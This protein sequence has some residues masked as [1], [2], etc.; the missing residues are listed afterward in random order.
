MSGSIYV[1]QESGELIA[2]HETTYD[3]E[4]LL[5]GL[6]AKHPD[7]LA[8][9]QM[10]ADTP[11]RWLL[12]SREM[13]VPGSDDST[14]RW[15]LDHLFLDQDAVPTLVEVKRSCDTRIRREVVGQLLDYAANG[16][17]YWPVETVQARFEASCAADGRDPAVELSTLIG[18]DGDPSAFW[19]QVKTNLQAGRIRLVF[20]ADVIP[21]EL[22]RVIEFLNRQ[23]DPAEVLGVEVK[24][25][26]GPGVTTLVPRV[27]GILDRRKPAMVSSERQPISEHEFWRV[28]DEAR[29][30]PERAA[31]RAI[32]EWSRAKGLS[33]DFKTG[34]KGPVFVATVDDI[35]QSIA[36]LALNARGVVVFQM[37]WMVRRP[38]FRDPGTQ[39]ELTGRLILL[40]GLEAKAA[41]GLTGFPRIPLAQ[42]LSAEA[43]AQ[44][45][46]LLDWVVAR[47]RSASSASVVD[48]SE[49]A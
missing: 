18:E 14:G 16:L 8:G 26:V 15:S 27:L 43:R 11:R 12:V 33:G 23:M 1:L 28:F 48:Q 38:P 13:T 44:L 31:A 32:V 21:L 6:L 17:A 45:F 37:R 5:Q 42:L 40:P 29:P 34:A 25:Y 22:R 7:L 47:L 10:N 4:A 46:D 19:Q 3:S 30:A 39:Q 36:V 20:V 2:A 49:P 35:G 41:A 24:Q 9:D